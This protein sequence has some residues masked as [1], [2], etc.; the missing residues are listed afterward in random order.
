MAR[1]T[2]IV[3][4]KIRLREQLRRDIERIAIRNDRSVNSE[5]V[6]LLEAAVIADKA[7]II[8]ID[9]M[10]RNVKAASAEDAIQEIIRIWEAKT[11]LV[12]SE[13]KSARLSGAKVKDEPAAAE[14][15]D[16]SE[17]LQKREERQ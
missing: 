1:A 10:I 16:A 13:P 2:E 3:A 15:P 11:G 17:A 5:I 4:V 6:R 9:G 12:I 8:G 7:G 14:E